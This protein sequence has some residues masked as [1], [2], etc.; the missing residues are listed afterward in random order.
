[1][2]SNE[3]YTSLGTTRLQT[4]A[5]D[6]SKAK[7]ANY[8]F[9][10]PPRYKY[11]FRRITRRNCNKEGYTAKFCRMFKA[12]KHIGNT[13]FVS[14]MNQITA[15]QPIRIHLQMDGSGVDLQLDIVSILTLINKAL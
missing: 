3:G 12:D 13:L 5:A 4:C 11:H 10:H 9:T 14:A 1:M 2:T 8:G 7:C 15:E 6:N